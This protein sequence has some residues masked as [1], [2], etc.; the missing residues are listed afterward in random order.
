MAGTEGM[1]AA[2]MSPQGTWAGATGKAD[3]IRNLRVNDQFAIGSVTKTIVAA[4]VMRMVEYGL[5]DLDD[6]AEDHLPENLHFDTNDATIRQL[7]GHFSGIPDFWHLT[8]F[9]KSL[10]TDEQRRWKLAEVLDL[11]PKERSPAGDSFGYADTNYLLLGLVIE[12]VR[13]RP[14]AEVLSQ[15][16]LNIDGADRLI[17]QPHEK[18]TPP[19]AMPDGRSTTLLA[20]GGGY[21]PSIAGST[22]DREA[23]AMAS[24]APSLARWWRAFCAGEIVSQESLNE[25]STSVGDQYGLGL[26]VDAYPY[27]RSIGHAGTHVGYAAWAGCL[28]DEGSVV[29]VLTNQTT[30]NFAIALPLVEAASSVDDLITHPT[31]G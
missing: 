25:M 2:L 15:G 14:V 9:Q 23:G 20:R 8:E 13:D 29:V 10:R 5:I 7:L 17:Y 22:S 21:L 12:Q 11:V 4:E 28:P 27:P 24:D 1:A 16:V 18:P 26:F 30:S 3:G 19:M 6:P 31:D